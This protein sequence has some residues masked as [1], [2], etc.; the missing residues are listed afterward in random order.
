MLGA[1]DTHSQARTVSHARQH[2]HTHPRTLTRTHTHTATPA[3]TTN[4]RDRSR[5]TP[6]EV[7]HFWPACWGWWMW[8]F[9][10]PKEILL[11][12]V[13]FHY[14]FSLPSPLYSSSILQFSWVNLVT[15]LHCRQYCWDFLSD[16]QNSLKN[17]Q[18]NRNCLRQN[19]DSLDGLVVWGRNFLRGFSTRFRRAS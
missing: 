16:D 13:L 8:T 12:Q 2:Q 9:T 5:D 11:V 10:G 3:G 14:T 1:L 4:M 15:T 7:E 6:A 18:R 19:H 17:I